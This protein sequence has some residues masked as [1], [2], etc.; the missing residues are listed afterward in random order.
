V[1]GADA[2]VS[3]YAIKYVYLIGS[4]HM[5][6][7]RV[8]V[9][10]NPLE[11]PFCAYGGHCIEMA[12]DRSSQYDWAH[13]V[14]VEYKHEDGSWRVVTSREGTNGLDHSAGSVPDDMVGAW[15]NSRLGY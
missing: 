4:S 2:G 15:H 7:Y 8:S 13:M 10:V 6:Q 5:T 9:S 3:T 1:P 11:T 12:L 14:S